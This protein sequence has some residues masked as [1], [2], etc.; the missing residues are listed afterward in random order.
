MVPHSRFNEVNEEAKTNRARVLEL[1]ELLARA[2]GGTAPA[3]AKDDPKPA[4]YDYDAA[5]ELYSAA[6]LDGDTAKAKTIRAEIRTNERTQAVREAEEAADRRY[7][8][9]RQKDD[10]TRAQ[11]ERD[12]AI[13][14]AYVAFPFLDSASADANQDA[15]DEVLALTNLYTGKGKSVGEALSAAVSKVGPRYAPAV[16]VKDV[17]DPKPDLQKGIDRAK[18]IPPKGAG[19]GTRTVTTDVRKMTGSEIKKLSKEEDARLG[20]DEI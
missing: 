5:E 8:A 19:L 2:K 18:Q 12:L 7:A 14:K 11:T 16:V 17:V 4:P 15:I 20:G 13:A 3:V 1:E 9:N 6:I 10:L